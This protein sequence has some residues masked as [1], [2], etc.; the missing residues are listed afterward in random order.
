[1]MLKTELQRVKRIQIKK[2]QWFIKKGLT[3]QELKRHKI[4]PKDFL[5]EHWEKQINKMG[6]KT[7]RIKTVQDM[8][9][10]TNQKNLEDFLSDLKIFLIS[11][12][13]LKSMDG[14]EEIKSKGFT[15]IDDGKYDNT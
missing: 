6:I 10:C 13:T 2:L 11:A 8:I 9:N 7:Y 5:D 15:W 3:R 12:H 4:F 1:M 14:M